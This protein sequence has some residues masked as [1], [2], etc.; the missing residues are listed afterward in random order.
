MSAAK[1]RSFCHCHIVLAVHECPTSP[2]LLLLATCRCHNPFNQ[3]HSTS[4]N[5]GLRFHSKPTCFLV[6]F[7]ILD[8]DTTRHDEVEGD[9]QM[10]LLDDDP[11]V[12][13]SLII[14]HAGQLVFDFSRILLE[15][16]EPLHHTLRNQ[17]NKSNQEAWTKWPP[18][19]TEFCFTFRGYFWKHL[20]VT[21]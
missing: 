8:L 2:V 9:A 3:Y 17:V 6:N 7:R 1:W 21:T 5:T 16:L 19:C 10:T 20:W 15:T 4:S 13:E 11:A 12:V 18:F 14:E